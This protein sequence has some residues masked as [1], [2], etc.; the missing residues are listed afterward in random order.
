MI[1]VFGLIVNICMN[2]EVTKV[3]I[4]CHFITFGVDEL[5]NHGISFLVDLR[6][7]LDLNRDLSS[8]QSFALL[9]Y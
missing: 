8:L 3:N 5:S 9:L 7:L 2:I 6:D 4:E 1:S